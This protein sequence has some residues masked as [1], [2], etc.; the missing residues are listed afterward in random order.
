MKRNLWRT[1]SC[2]PVETLLDAIS[3]NL[4]H[5]CSQQEAGVEKSLDAARR[6]AY[7]TM[8]LFDITPQSIPAR[9]RQAAAG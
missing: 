5:A 4:V 9:R 8:S 1:H 6:S 3:R 2:V 7:A